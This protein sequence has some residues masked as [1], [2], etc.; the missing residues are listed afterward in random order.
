MKLIVEDLMVRDVVTINDEYSVKYASRMMTYFDISSL[1][2]TSMEKVTGILTEKDIMTRVVAKGLDPEK[3]TAKDIMSKPVLVVNPTTRL[4]DAVE[5]M[6]Q[7]KIK[8]L[9]VMSDRGEDSELLGMLSITDVARIQPLILDSLRSASQLE[10]EKP[11]VDN[12]FY[13][14]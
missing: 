11:E 3:V 14:R 12:S 10:P 13:V 6:I 2:V 1:V 4:E 9:P 5:T 8:K 7:K